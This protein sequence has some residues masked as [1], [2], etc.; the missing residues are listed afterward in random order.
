MTDGMIVMIGDIGA[1][2]YIPT[3][4]S[5]LDER[6]M[7]SQLDAGYQHGGGW[8]DFEG[9]EASMKG[10]VWVIQYPNDPPYIERARVSMNG[11]T[12]VMFDHAWVM[13]IDREGRK[14]FCRMD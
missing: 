3:M 8:K 9:F 7:V 5:P 14:R 2:G 12:L 13:V 10:A 6:D 4:L 1:L 11:E